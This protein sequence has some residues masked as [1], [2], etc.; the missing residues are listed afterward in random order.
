[1]S[2]H[3]SI[4][5]VIIAIAIMSSSLW[6]AGVELRTS[7]TEVIEGGSIDL[8]IIAE[9][10][11]IELPE[12]DDIGGFPVEGRSVSTKLES[13]YVNGS[14]STKNKKTLS[15]RFFPETDMTIPAF[16]VKIDGKIYSTKKLPVKMIEAS[17]IKSQSSNGYLMSMSSDKQSVYTG[18]SFIITVDFF[19]PRSSSVVKVEYT[20]PKFKNF[21]SK[22]LGK[23]KLLKSARGTIHKLQYLLTAKKDGN[24]TII[25]PKARVGIKNFNGANR[26]PWGFFSNDI[27]WKSIRAKSLTVVVEPLPSDADLIGDFTVSSSVDT[28]KSKPNTP[29][30]YTIK[31]EGDGNL[32]DIADPK[33]DLPGV[34][35]YADDAKTSS[36]VIDGKL[37]S[38]YER[39]Y[40][41]IS[42]KSFTIPSFTFKVFDYKKKQNK[43]LRTKRFDISIDANAS[44]K[45][46][47]TKTTNK[48]SSSVKNVMSDKVPNKDKD[49]L[50]DTKYYQDIVQESKNEYGLL[51]LLI[52][53]LAGILSMLLFFVAKSKL[54]DSKI[55]VAPQHRYSDKEA[56]E[57]LY[58]HINESSK[59]ENMVR[60][61]YAKSRGDKS[62]KIDK[63]E[64]DKLISEVT[65][66]NR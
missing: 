46:T 4:I 57:I 50:E 48:T 55:R 14:F 43:K 19:E 65:K 62:I 13:S 8:Q 40:V 34:T 9:G 61:I 37:K 56:L 59:I 51:Y 36:S 20:A 30:S 7:S 11:N 44:P 54:K 28:T 42:D 24:F 12:I 23:E 5:K 3:G 10:S 41:F 1:M 53:Y 38:K 45:A 33:F 29:V 18:E 35:V 63:K 2:I 26:D 60:K 22:A 66:E 49:I 16:K 27:K 25:P 15:F 31:I 39:K 21:F 52:A 64:L 32:E 58:P 17:Q 47:N 6:S